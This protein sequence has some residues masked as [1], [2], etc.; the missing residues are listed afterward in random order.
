MVSPTPDGLVCDLDGVLYRGETPLP[1]APEAVRHLRRR[2]VRLLF[3]SNNSR[4]TVAQYI[5]KLSRMGIEASDDEVLTSAVVIGEELVRRKLEES[6][7]FVVGGEGL[8]QAVRGAGLSLVEGDEGRHAGLVA[9]GWDREFTYEKMRLA[10]LAVR[11]GAVFLAT[12]DDASFPAADGLW[13]GAGA[14]LAA[15]EVGSGRRAEVVGKPH[16]PMRRVVAQRLEGCRRIAVVGDRVETDIAMGRAV[17]WQTILVLSGV[18]SAAQARALD[19]PP[20]LILDSIADMAT[21]DQ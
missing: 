11:S 19:P 2:G 6:S 15:I 1:G 18:T 17:G 5:A 10:A 9:V 20:D 12:N 13:P 4:P 16:E 7:A 14:V 21:E 3:C 8:A